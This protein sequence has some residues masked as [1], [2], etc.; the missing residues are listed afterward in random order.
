M[1][2]NNSTPVQAIRP[3]ELPT[4]PRERYNEAIVKIN[5]F[6]IKEALSLNNGDVVTYFFD[7]NSD[8]G[9]IW[10]VF[11]EEI[12]TAYRQAGW[13]IHDYHKGPDVYPGWGHYLLF[14]KPTP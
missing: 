10:H 8:D 11:G 9:L 6:L 5:A 4:S 2:E 3:D 13:G 12:I 14:R 7:F 1:A